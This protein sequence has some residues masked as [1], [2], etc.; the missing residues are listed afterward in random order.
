METSWLEPPPIRQLRFLRWRSSCHQLGPR[1]SFSPLHLQG[2]IF[3][4][5]GRNLQR[6]FCHRLL[7]D[8][9]YVS[10]HGWNNLWASK[11]H[12]KLP[13]M[14]SLPQQ[15]VFTLSGI[16]IP[17]PVFSITSP[18][19][20]NASLGSSNNLPVTIANSGTAAGTVSF[21][22]LAAPFPRQPPRNADLRSIPQL[23]AHST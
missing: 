7:Q 8:R 16:G 23:R 12:G 19:F 4:R 13:A 17:Q 9:D 20:A 10:S 5:N 3:P 1:Q 18:S 22:A 2:R 6:G 11:H 15:F 14:E 21:S